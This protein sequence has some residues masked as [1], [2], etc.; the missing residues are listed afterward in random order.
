MW[1]QNY[2]ASGMPWA[3]T[4][5][6]SS[7][8]TSPDPIPSSST[9]PPPTAIVAPSL[10]TTTVPSAPPAPF[11]SD[12][13]P[14]G[15][16]ATAAP[17]SFQDAFDFGASDSKD[18]KNQGWDSEASALFSRR[19]TVENM[20]R[21][22]KDRTSG[23]QRSAVIY[24]VGEHFSCAA[25]KQI[26]HLGAF[27][28]LPSDGSKRNK[29]L[30]FVR[31]AR[32]KHFVEAF[33]AKPEICED[34]GFRLDPRKGLVSSHTADGST[35]TVEELLL[36][37]LTFLTRCRGHGD[38]QNVNART[39]KATIVFFANPFE[40]FVGRVK[41]E[42]L[43]LL[44]SHLK[45]YSLDGLFLEEVSNCVDVHSLSSR[46][47][48][49]KE[50][51]Q[52]NLT[53]LYRQIARQP[54]PLESGRVPCD[55]IASL[56]AV[57]VRTI[58]RLSGSGGD[59]DDLMR[60]QS[61]RKPK[62]LAYWAE[63]APDWPDLQLR[64]MDRCTL[65]R[66]WEPIHS[67]ELKF[68][69]YYRVDPRAESTWVK[70]YIDETSGDWLG[71]RN[72]DSDSE[73]ESQLQANSEQQE[74]PSKDVDENTRQG[75]HARKNRKK[76]AKKREKKVD[77]DR[78]PEK[79]EYGGPHKPIEVDSMSTG[80]M[81]KVERWLEATCESAAAAGQASP[82]IEV[83][84]ME[85]ESQSSKKDGEATAGGQKA[86]K[87]D[88]GEE[89]ENEVE[90]LSS[91][92]SRTTTM[93]RNSDETESSESNESASTVSSKSSGKQTR[94][95]VDATDQF[96]DQLN[97]GVKK[98]KVSSDSTVKVL[99][100]SCRGCTEDNT[101]STWPPQP[102]RNCEEFDVFF[103]TSSRCRNT[104]R[105]PDAQVSNK[106]RLDDTVLA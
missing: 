69:S 3:P 16:A 8:Y 101:L 4:P 55:H 68:G 40:A 67:K 79:D 66:S 65:T 56:L 57:L 9:A 15:S 103:V 33:S 82:N 31:S 25:Y 10:S 76:K 13:R 28:N 45:H 83:V 20:F 95:W 98:P 86:K 74:G 11:I 85:T 78:E 30:T 80:S 81:E 35:C 14:L 88:G 38:P 54:S 60:E 46:L 58:D 32:P 52:S 84:D 22:E 7:L 18:G 106:H 6:P 12:C 17:P 5:D 97:V 70:V 89:A 29:E 39:P 105:H 53:H 94:R 64:W 49:I 41:V 59:P 26:T 104:S 1:P 19:D 2:S 42:L 47:G 51:T 37:F 75:K 61:K 27:F 63:S 24:V 87:A 48:L 72:L 62:E 96:L 102:C 92:G 100:R 34:I 50:N 21:S 36:D 77:A 90:I 44:F 71:V 73:E 23:E 91:A 99:D 43:S 93:S